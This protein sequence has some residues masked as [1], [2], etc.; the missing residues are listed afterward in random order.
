MIN[1]MLKRGRLGTEKDNAICKQ[2]CLDC[3]GCNKHSIKCCCMLAYVI[4]HAIEKQCFFASFPWLNQLKQ[5]YSKKLYKKTAGNYHILYGLQW[6]AATKLY[7]INTNTAVSRHTGCI[8]FRGNQCGLPPN[9]L[10][11]AHL[12]PTI[13]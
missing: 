5:P 7:Y 12:H 13:Q 9:N 6:Q 10:H 4:N 1:S 3:H 11:P 8:Y 2:G